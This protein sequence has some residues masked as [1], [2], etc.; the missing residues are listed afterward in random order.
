MKVRVPSFFKKFHCVASKCH[1]TC[2]AGWE[3]DVDEVSQA[4]YAN[5]QGSFGDKLRSKIVDG[6]FVLA[7]NERC[8][9]LNGQNLCE[10][11]LHLGKDSLCDICR[12]H[13]RFIDVF[14]DLKEQG[15]GLCCEE[16]VR[17]LLKSEGHLA[18]DEFL[19]SEV[20]EILDEESLDARNSAIAIRTEI[21]ERLS[22]GQESLSKRLADILLLTASFSEETTDRLAEPSDEIWKHQIQVLL[23]GESLGKE[24]DASKIEIQH[25]L[26]TGLPKNFLRLFSD[27][28][29]EK[30]VA[31]QIFR[32]FLKSL[33]DGDML[34]KVK[35]SIY[36]WLV[37]QRLGRELSVSNGKPSLSICAVKL[38][39][40]QLEYSDENMEMLADAFR[41]NAYF[42]TGAFL[43]L[44][45][46]ME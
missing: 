38:L 22:H 45:S 28:D 13:P 27:S 5:V 14:G 42:S 15:I 46:E 24:W 23:Q 16:S 3:V 17:L 30:I 25:S 43:K 39:S 36:F 11:Y 9:F 6:H 4:R 34:S 18:W 35:F 33:Y 10:I 44:L 21:L 12:E 32:Y 31:Y 41:E 20:P 8:P 1:D 19:D 40:K 7:E 26:Q 37:L 2:C 29:G